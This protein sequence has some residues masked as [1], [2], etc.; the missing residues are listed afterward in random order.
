MRPPSAGALLGLRVGAFT[1]SL[2]RSDISAAP[3]DAFH[4]TA[5]SSELPRFTAVGRCGWSLV[6]PSTRIPAEHYAELR[7]FSWSASLK[8]Y[9]VLWVI[10]PHSNDVTFAVV[11]RTRVWRACRGSTTPDIGRLA[12]GAARGRS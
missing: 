3:I 7:S 2:R 11:E 8:W 6:L 9:A 10:S 4:L 5:G 12:P 1:A